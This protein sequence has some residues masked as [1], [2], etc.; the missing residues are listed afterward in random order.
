MVI[1]SSKIVLINEKIM[2]SIQF[3]K[4]AIDYVK[5]FVAEV[6]HDLVDIFFLFQQL[7]YLKMMMVVFLIIKL[8]KQSMDITC[9]KFDRLNSGIVIRPDQLRLT[10]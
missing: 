1:V 4:F 3:P 6:G 2:I 10:V 9:N 7:N 5:V 8:S